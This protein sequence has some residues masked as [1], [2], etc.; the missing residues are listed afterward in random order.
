MNVLSL[1]RLAWR[2]LWRQKRR[3]MLTLA[4]IVFGG[5]LAILMTSLQDQVW[6]DFIDSAARLGAGH[7]TVQHEEYRDTPTLTRTV[8][9][10]DAIR[11]AAKADP[12]V[13]QVVD[14]TTGSVMLSTAS[15]SYGGFFIGFEPEIETSETMEFAEDIVVGKAFT[16]SSDK[17]IILGKVLATNLN[18]EL[19]DK[20]VYT[21]T[22]RKGEIVSGMERVSGIV[23]TGALST[24]AALVLLP[25][26]TVQSLLGYDKH[27]STQ[28]AIFLE[29]GRNA[30]AVA[31]RL[32]NQVD[33]SATVLTWDELQPEIKTFVAM[34]VGGGRVMI[35]IIGALV[36]AGIF[37]T[38]FMSVLERTREF[39][40]MLAI[41][42]TPGQLSL[43]VLIESA[44][45]AIM[46]LIGTALISA[47]PYYALSKTGIDIS[48]Q[49]EA[50]GGSMDIGG[51]GMSSVMAVG[52]YPESVVAIAILL[53]LATMSAGLYPAWK[54]GRVHPVESINLV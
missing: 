9:N 12:D 34:K 45:L 4:S 24:D 53:V 31:E 52:I 6:A 11:T 29:D 33:A 35:I 14:R 42:Y 2:N 43:L 30:I 51:V 15:D 39:G 37:N 27:E 19:G 10:T 16:S 3:T 20:V 46:G 36:A 49:L 32:S 7:V 18:A 47:Y 48:S 13:S 21:L 25:L 22:D 38:I 17:G 28:V 23:N 54:A 50:A 41:G 8:K 1:I 40:I 5:F 44:F 26:N